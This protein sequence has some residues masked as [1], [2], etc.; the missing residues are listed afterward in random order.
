MVDT[1]CLV[2]DLFVDGDA[3]RVMDLVR[4]HTW[5]RLYASEHLIEEAADVI[6]HLAEPSLADAWRDR[7][8]QMIERVDHPSEDHPAMASAYA[9]QTAHLISYDERLGSAQVGLSMRKAMPISIRSPRA[10]LS[11]FDPESLYESLFEEPYPGPDHG[12]RE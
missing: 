5:L 2:A 11:V 10:F 7:F 6:E 9:G 12:S 8:E 1:D 4:S 3:R